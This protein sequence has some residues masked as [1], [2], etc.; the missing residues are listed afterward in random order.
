MIRLCGLSSSSSHR[1]YQTGIRHVGRLHNGFVNVVAKSGASSS[2][3]S[4]SS[5]TLSE[6]IGTVSDPEHRVLNIERSIQSSEDIVGI[7]SRCSVSDILTVVDSAGG[8]DE[9][10]GRPLSFHRDG[11]SVLGNDKIPRYWRGSFESVPSYMGQYDVIICNMGNSAE[12]LRDDL[13]KSSLVTRP[14]GSIILWS[15]DASETFSRDMLEKVVHDLC[16]DVVDVGCSSGSV[17][18]LRVPKNYA[19]ARGPVYMKGEIVQGYGRGSK[20]LGVPTANLAIPDVEDQIAGLP[21]GV[22]FGW[23]QLLDSDNGVYKMVMNIGKRPTFVKD[24]SPD[25]SVE[26]HVM[27]SYDHDFYGETMKVVL[28][29]YLRPEIP[30]SGLQELL[31]RIHTD[32]GISRTQL[33]S[34]KW[35]EFANDEF[36][37]SSF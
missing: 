9:K 31:N 18:H 27:H 30:F 29:G 12:T 5:S 11:D 23:A 20:E 4:S 36:F 13:L 1:L 6:L 34:E 7:L 26:A 19:F 22:Y 14:G 33:D 37:N 15:N 32:I 35:S 21:L 17:A 24:N 3:S 25:S 10:E 8:S 2:S 16:I 28:L